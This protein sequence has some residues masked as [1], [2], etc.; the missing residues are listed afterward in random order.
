MINC[1]ECN[2]DCCK[3][4]VLPLGKKQE[5]VKDVLKWV[6]SHENLS[7]GI[8]NDNVGVIIK[9]KCKFLKDNK[10]SIYED[11]FG[12]CRNYDISTCSK[13]KQY[14]GVILNNINDIEHY[15]K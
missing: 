13:N 4:L 1:D 9:S 3:R 11:R 6:V 8:E 7:I 5:M 15:F 14:F 2:A 12:V 10:C